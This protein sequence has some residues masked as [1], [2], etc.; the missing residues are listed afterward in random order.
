MQHSLDWLTGSPSAYQ[1][2][3]LVRRVDATGRRRVRD[4]TDNN[5]D[6]KKNVIMIGINSNPMNPVT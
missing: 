1:T 3:S 5:C 4:G 6:S 2:L